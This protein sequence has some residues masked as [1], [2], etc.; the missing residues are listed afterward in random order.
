MLVVT[1]EEAAIH[2]QQPSEHTKDE[3]KSKNE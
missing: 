3:P 1:Q 2:A